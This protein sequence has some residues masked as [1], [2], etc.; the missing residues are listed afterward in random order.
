MLQLQ[1]IK[2]KDGWVC[3]DASETNVRPA[4][5]ALGDDED[6]LFLCKRAWRVFVSG[7]SIYNGNCPTMP[8]NCHEGCIYVHPG[9]KEPVVGIDK[10]E[11]MYL[12]V[13]S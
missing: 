7:I 3:P 8:H 2:T 11:E 12:I 13:E 5:D 1:P 10:L 4:I 9:D 6:H